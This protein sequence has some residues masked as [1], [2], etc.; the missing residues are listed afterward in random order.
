MSDL[1][2]AEQQQAQ[3]VAEP[4]LEGRHAAVAREPQQRPESR[5]GKPGGE[6]GRGKHDQN[7]SPFPQWEPEESA[8]RHE[9]HEHRPG[10]G[11]SQR[12]LPGIAGRPVVHRAAG[13]AGRVWQDLG[14]LGPYRRLI[15][16]PLIS[17]RG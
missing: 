8:L 4:L 12:G 16:T 15:V 7:P 3:W 2:D 5:H 13:V 11:G 10:G 14:V 1:L 9:L 6:Q 17:D